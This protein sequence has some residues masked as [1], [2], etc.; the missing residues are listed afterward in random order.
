VTVPSSTPLSSPVPNA[1]THTPPA[2]WSVDN[3]NMPAAGL[4]DNDKGVFELEGWTFTTKDFWKFAGQSASR[5]D[6]FTKGDGNVALADSDEY[7]DLN[8][9][10]GV[11]KPFNS[12]LKSPVLNITGIAPGDLMLKF[13]SDW[14]PEDDQTAI[15]TVDYGNGEVEVMHWTSGGA[16]L[17]ATNHNE[18]V[19]IPLNNPAG[20]TTAVVTFK[21]LMASNNWFWAV[22]NVAIGVGVVPEPSSLAI[23]FG[24]AACG[25]LPLRRVRRRHA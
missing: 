5:V 10:D 16:L 24:A 7:D 19:L 6:E 3:S 14:E 9:G 11:T 15:I 18:T 21:Y 20:A 17:H 13:D 12:L 23:L 1:F 25:V 4:G 22:D 2:N 8:G